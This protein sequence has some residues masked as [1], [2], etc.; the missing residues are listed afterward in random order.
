[1][2]VR[3]KVPFLLAFCK[4]VHPLQQRNRTRVAFANEYVK[5]DRKSFLRMVKYFYVTLVLCLCH[6]KA[7]CGIGKVQNRTH[8]NYLRHHFRG[9]VLQRTLLRAVMY[10][11]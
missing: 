1:M 8:A 4:K 6:P 9:Q 10:E 7:F 2:F 3:A 5:I 11:Q